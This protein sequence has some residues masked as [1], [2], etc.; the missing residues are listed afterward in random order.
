MHYCFNP[1]D[2]T[3]DISYG[4]GVLQFFRN[5]L[6]A[7]IKQMPLEF[8]QFALYLVLTH[9]SV[10]LGFHLKYSLTMNVSA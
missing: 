10:L 9:L 8:F 1:G 4:F 5:R 6:R 7:Q 2:I 3:P